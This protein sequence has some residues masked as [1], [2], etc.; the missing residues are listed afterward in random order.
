MTSFAKVIVDDGS[1]APGIRR[2]LGWSVAI[3]L[4]FSLLILLDL[5]ILRIRIVD[6]YFLSVLPVIATFLWAMATAL[7]QGSPV[8]FSLILAFVAPIL[9]GLTQVLGSLGL[10]EATAFVDEA[11]YCA[12]VLLIIGTSAGV[13]DRFLAIKAERDRARLTARKL[14]TMANSDGLTGLLNRRAFDQTR[15]LARGRALLLADIDRFKVINDTFGH[16]R[17]DAVL[18]HAARVIEEVV[19][20]HGGGEVYR[21]GGEEFAILT[22]PADPAVMRHIAEAIRAAVEESAEADSG[23]DMPDITISIGAVMGEGQLMHV[24]YAEADGALYRAKDL[25]RNRCEFAQ[26]A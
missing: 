1:V 19:I 22:P 18:C 17:G 12:L 13:G 15:C 8:A 2:A 9:A 5:E 7:R 23:Y 26:P 14:G 24:A 25:G 21:L 11:V 20:Q 16:Q 3:T 6:A 4:G 10:F